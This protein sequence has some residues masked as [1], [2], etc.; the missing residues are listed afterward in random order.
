MSRLLI[1]LLLITAITPFVN[2]ITCRSQKSSTDTDVVLETGC[3]ACQLHIKPDKSEVLGC[4][5][6]PA[7]PD[8]S[9]TFQ[10]TAKLNECVHWQKLADDGTVAE[11]QVVVYCNTKDKCNVECPAVEFPKPDGDKKKKK[12]KDKSSEGG[13][14]GSAASRLLVLTSVLIAMIWW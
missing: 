4:I 14:V 1:R 3:H 10:V 11:T 12:K 2:S 9:P 13:S 5:R 8:Y 6:F 7:P